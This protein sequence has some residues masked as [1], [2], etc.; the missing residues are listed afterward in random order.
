MRSTAGHTSGASMRTAR[1]ARPLVAIALLAAL[2]CRGDDVTAPSAR[3]RPP[4]TA[5]HVV[6]TQ[7]YNGGAPSPRAFG[8]DSRRPGVFT[9]QGVTQPGLTCGPGTA[10]AA[11]VCSGYLASAV[12]STRLDVT[13]KIPAATATEPGPFP[14]VVLVHG[15]GGSK[16]SDGE[17]DDRL[18]AHHFT[19]LRYS[20]RGF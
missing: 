17:Y 14:L 10:P 5:R 4:G 11:T 20:T 8:R 15:Y 18:L 19:V 9:G 7:D 1:T 13:V 3:A 6:A 2:A 12:D 16:T